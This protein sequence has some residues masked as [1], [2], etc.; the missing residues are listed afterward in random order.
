MTEAEKQTFISQLDKALESV[1]PH[2]AEDGGNV[3]IV[4]VTPEM[5]VQVKWEGNCEFCDMSV[6]TLRA[7]IEYALKERFPQIESV[8][9]INGHS[10]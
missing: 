7:G 2:L 4:D 8:I 6:S 1:R 3:Q 9:A 10:S 5:E